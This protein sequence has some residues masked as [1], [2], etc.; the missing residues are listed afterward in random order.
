M[1]KFGVKPTVAK[2][3]AFITLGLACLSTSI[4]ANAITPTSTGQVPQATQNGL[5]AFAKNEKYGSVRR[6]LLDGG[7]QP[8]HDP[9]ADVCE[10]GDKRCEGRP[11]M[12]ACAGTGMANCRFL[13]K[14]DGKTL[15][16]FTVGEVEAVFNGMEFLGALPSNQANTPLQTAE[17]SRSIVQINIKDI[18]GMYSCGTLNGVIFFPDGAYIDIFYSGTRSESIPLMFSLGTY[19]L[20]DGI[21]TVKINGNVN[22]PTATNSSNSLVLKSRVLD[23][24]ASGFKTK[25]IANIRNGVP[26]NTLGGDIENCVLKSKDTKSAN[27]T[28]AILPAMYFRK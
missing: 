10:T 18:T 22:V 19:D 1:I 5:P 16:I 11:E 2:S 14:R 13:W 17:S 25:R 6:K 20:N 12:E 3:L 4:S 28:R 7:W 21:L 9:N 24:N 27:G 8:F 26:A 15:V 23:F